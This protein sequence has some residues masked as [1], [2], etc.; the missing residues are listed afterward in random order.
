MSKG[1]KLK[2][3]LPALTRALMRGTPEAELTQSPIKS[4]NKVLKCKGKK[5]TTTL[6]TEPSNEVSCFECTDTFSEI[7]E[8]RRHMFTMHSM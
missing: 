4:K 3:V 6:I 8:R 1:K 2:V 5:S 7:E